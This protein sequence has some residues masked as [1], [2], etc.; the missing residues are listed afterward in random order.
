VIS[1]LAHDHDHSLC[2]NSKLVNCVVRDTRKTAAE[3]EK[4]GGEKKAKRAILYR[5]IVSKS[6]RELIIISWIIIA[7]FVCT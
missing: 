1:H 4:K 2:Q 7:S 5:F 3:E 6:L